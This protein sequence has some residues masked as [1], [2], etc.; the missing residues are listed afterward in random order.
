[1]ALL[2]A[3]SFRCDAEIL[4][5]QDSLTD[6]KKRLQVKIGLNLDISVPGVR[7]IHLAGHRRNS[8]FTS[9]IWAPTVAKAWSIR[10]PPGWDLPQEVGV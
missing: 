6:Q 10:R 3:H 5:T 1:M 9:N 2:T 7:Q 8:G 4:R